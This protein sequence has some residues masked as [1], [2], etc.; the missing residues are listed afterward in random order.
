MK[1]YKEK[2]AA[3][4]DNLIQSD[5]DKLQQNSNNEQAEDA[6]NGKE[7]E[8]KVSSEGDASEDEVMKDCLLVEFSLPPS[9]YATMV[10]REFLVDPE[11]PLESIKSSV[12]AERNKRKEEEVK[13]AGDTL[14]D[15]GAKKPKT[16]SSESTTTVL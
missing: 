12:G 9:S 13:A 1:Q 8:A 2:D 14:L 3:S 7:E 10:L 6:T 11:K 4:L 16:D 15:E 5:W